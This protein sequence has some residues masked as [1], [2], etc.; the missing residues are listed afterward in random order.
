MCSYYM[1]KAIDKKN[2][3]E[4]AAKAAGK[5]TGRAGK[6]A[7]KERGKAAGAAGKEKD[8]AAKASTVPM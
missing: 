5:E 6:A 2:A 4:K 1:W 8:N 7:G 3:A